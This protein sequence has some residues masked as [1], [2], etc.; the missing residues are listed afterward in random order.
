MK[1]FK[2]ARQIFLRQSGHSDCGLSCLAMILL[3]SGNSADAAKLIKDTEKSRNE[4]S[5]LELKELSVRFGLQ[6]RCVTMDLV[7]L[8]NTTEPAILHTSNSDDSHHFVLYISAELRNNSWHYLIADPDEGIR[9]ISEPDLINLWKSNAAVYFEGLSFRHPVKTIPFHIMQMWFRLIPKSIFLSIPFLNLCAAISGV[10]LSWVLQRGISE[11]LNDKPLTLVAAVL[12]LLLIITFSKNVMT[13]LRQRIL[14]NI[15]Q[16]ANHLLVKWFLPSRSDNQLHITNQK[17][18]KHVLVQVRKVQNAVIAFISVIVADGSMI[19]ILHSALFFL[20]PAAGTF[21]LL[22]TLFTFFVASRQNA[23]I[24]VESNLVADLQRLSEKSLTQIE[25]RENQLNHTLP[26]KDTFERFNSYTQKAKSLSI[27]IGRHNFFYD[28]IGTV[29]VIVMFALCLFEISRLDLSYNDLLIIVLF[30]Y[31]I[32]SLIPKV[33]NA[34]FVIREGA[35][36]FRQLQNQ[37]PPA[38]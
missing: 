26:E 30:T 32:F 25:D 12:T 13:Y 21:C 3:Y 38:N 19:A 10:A 9:L 2:R 23:E 20:L 4:L 29:T 14:I 31:I 35:D 16:R 27:K 34:L 7:H 15:N 36:A 8:R 17:T 18:L 1:N 11:S 5:L 33:C 24:Y 37:I 6:A 28:S 22:V